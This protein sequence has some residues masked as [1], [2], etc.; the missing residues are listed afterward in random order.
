MRKLTIA[1]P[2]YK[3]ETELLRCVNSIEF[4]EEY[5]NDIEIVISNND[6]T[7]DFRYNNNPNQYFINYN[8][9][10]NNLGIMGNMLKIIELSN[11]EFIFF[12]TDD[13]YFLPGS[14]EKIINFVT[15]IPQSVNAFKVGIITHLIK[16]NKIFQ[17][18]YQ[19]EQAASFEEKQQFIL[20]SSHIFSGSC[21]RRESI[22]AIDF[23]E[24]YE[25]YY[26]TT[27][28]LFGYN[29]GN[30][31]YLNDLLIIHTWQNEVYWDFA[32]PGS[33][34]LDI[35]WNEMCDYLS[36]YHQNNSFNFIK[37]VLVAQN[38]KET[39]HAHVKFFRILNSIFKL[40]GFKVIRLQ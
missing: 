27:S 19:I 35:N 34:E 25:K 6:P 28:L 18:D 33:K 4:I 30:L 38:K 13:D 39:I 7:S 5:K 15:T 20:N 22:P 26:Y 23:T 32:D 40:L 17:N 24:N 3:R 16:S 21:I 11:S 12:I 9:N 2:T 29:Y 31:E 14:I 36:N 1:I 10:K 8:K 37:K